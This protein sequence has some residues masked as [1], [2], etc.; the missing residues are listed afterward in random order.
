MYSFLPLPFDGLTNTRDLGG[1]PAADGKTVRPK[2]L[3]RSAQLVGA[4]ENDLRTLRDEYRLSLVVDFRSDAERATDPDPAIPGAETHVLELLDNDAIGVDRS[5]KSVREMYRM[6]AKPSF[7]AVEY[8]KPFYRS[9]VSGETSR[10]GYAEFFRLLLAMSPD[11]SALFHCT[12]GKDRTGMATVYLL[13]AFGTPREVI[14]RDYLSQNETCRDS[15]E[16]LVKKHS[17]GIPFIKKNIRALYQAEAVYL[18]TAFD[19][20][21]RLSGSPEAY[22]KEGLGL[23]DAELE[24]LREAFLA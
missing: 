15:I 19:E 21:K 24:A 3:L 13:T 7:D 11:S 22:L 23:T 4:S 17:K 8:F 20:M 6:V 14:Y 2:R 12:A 9:L 5:K 18:D 16:V 1:F 10:R